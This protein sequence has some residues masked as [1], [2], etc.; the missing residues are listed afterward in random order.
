MKEALESTVVIEKLVAGGFGLARTE[1]GKVILTEGVIPGEQVVVR[2][3]REKKDFVLA[4]PLRL[5]APS[6]HRVEPLCPVYSSCGGCDLQHIAYEWQLVYKKQI[7]ADL[8]ARNGLPPSLVENEAAISASPHQWGYRQRIRLHVDERNRTLGFH[9]KQSHRVQAI[10]SCPLAALS[11]NRVLSN[12]Q[13][14]ETFAALLAVIEEVE[15]LHNPHSEKIILLLHWRR[16][17]RPAERKAMEEI[18]SAIDPIEG[19]FIQEK[20]GGRLGLMG[21]ANGWLK[22]GFTIRLQAFGLDRELVFGVE[23][24]A[25]SQVNLAQNEQMANAVVRWAKELGSR[26]LLDLHCGMGNFAL[27]L[28]TAGLTVCGVDQQRASIRAAGE[29][30]DRNGLTSCRF[31]RSSAE[32]AVKQFVAQGEKFDVLLLDPPRSGCREVIDS[33]GVLGA[34]HIIYISCDPATMARDLA[35]ASA[36]GFQPKK[37]HL[38]D[39][40]PQTHHIESAVLLSRST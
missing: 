38:F 23:P 27:P 26:S 22:T 11:I 9:Q 4:A 16:K 17:V 33:C 39:M 40:F 3:I 25:F 15:L 5:L 36:L 24:G 21:A 1:D 8:F 2:P 12:L 35:H 28:A 6:P 32:E 7:V 14:S 34:K 30:A 13:K 18:F 31:L 20:G 29:N 10:D 37:A 19:V